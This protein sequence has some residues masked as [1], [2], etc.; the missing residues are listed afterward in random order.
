VGDFGFGEFYFDVPDGRSWYAQRLDLTETLGILLDVSAGVD[1]VTGQAFWQF[2][3]IDPATGMIPDDPARGFLPPNMTSPEGQGFVTYTVTP[4]TDALSGS[5]IDSAATIVFDTN[6]PMDTPPIFNTL[7]AEAPETVVNPLDPQQSVAS[8][9]VTWAGADRPGGSALRG[10]TIYVSTDGGPAEVWLADTQATQ[11][12]FVGQD[13]HIYA[14]YAASRDNAGNVERLVLSTPDAVTATPQTNDVPELELG[15]DLL[16]DE[17]EEILRTVAFVDGDPGDSWTVEIDYGDGSV[18]E[19]L[20]VDEP[21]FTLQHAYA[22]DGVYTVTV[23]VT[24]IPTGASDTDDLQVS[25]LNVAPTIDTLTG[26]GQVTVG[27]EASFSALATDVAGVADVLTYTWDFGDGSLAVTGENL[28]EMQHTYVQADHFTVTLT[29]ADGDGGTARDTWSITANPI[30][31]PTGLDLASVT[32]SGVSDTDNV[33][34]RNNSAAD[35]TLQF[36]VAGTLAGAT[37]TVY[38]DGVAVGEVLAAGPVTVVTT[39]GTHDLPDGTRVITARQGRAF[40]PQSQ[41]SPTQTITVDTAAPDIGAFGVSSTS[42]NWALGTIYSSMWIAGRDEPT[43]PWSVVDQLVIGF[44]EPVIAQAGEVT[45]ECTSAGPVNPTA[46]DGSG[47]AQ[48][49]CTMSGFLPMDR[50]TVFCAAGVTDVAGNAMGIEWA[51]G[52]DLLIA[53][54]N[55]DGHVS[56][57]DRRQ[58][59]DVYGSTLGDVNYV[60]HADLNGDGRVTSRDRR[61]QRDHYR[62]AL[63]AAMP[64][65]APS[66]VQSDA[67]GVLAGAADS[68]AQMAKTLP[69]A[70]LPVATAGEALPAS[71]VMSP[72]ATLNVPAIDSSVPSLCV[73]PFST[74]SFADA[75]APTAAQLV[76]S[77][78]TELGDFLG[79][80]LDTIMPEN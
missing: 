19:V 62:T 59:R 6:E 46:I 31:A 20:S 41:D 49:I 24:D 5:V 9:P 26:D 30:A 17:T 67:D 4:R 2:T 70:S 34:N 56:S 39:D 66:S 65:T 54:T 42:P 12:T 38:A 3:S 69:A 53:D 64:A 25:V 32:D 23:T 36:T 43:L 52:M 48:L 27:Y 7:D 57:R 14:F 68:M 18:P 74:A 58:L 33:T 73:H 77:L 50:Y 21:Q 47:T 76:P 51:E 78:E 63:P 60:T 72:E 22:D 15:G 44:D 11:A 16:A 61:I 79:E 37:V 1:V 45:L 29:V 8:F 75:D 10:Y 80:H 13:D 55:G 71:L 35:R 40:T 28:T